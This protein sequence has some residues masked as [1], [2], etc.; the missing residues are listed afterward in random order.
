VK[1]VE[2]EA[3]YK[4]SLKDASGFEKVDASYKKV[5]YVAHLGLSA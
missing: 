5:D 4:D 1:L 3:K 2:L